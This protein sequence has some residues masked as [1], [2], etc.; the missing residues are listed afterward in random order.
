MRDEED[1][2]Q[3]APLPPQTPPAKKK[4][5]GITPAAAAWLVEGSWSLIA[6][7]SKS[8]MSQ[9]FPPLQRLSDEE[10]ELSAFEKLV[11]DEIWEMLAQV[12]N[13][14]LV[15]GAQGSS[16]KKDTSSSELQRWFGIW[17]QVENTWGNDSKE[18]RD[19]F[20]SVKSKC[21]G[22]KGLG[23]D[24]FTYLFECNPTICG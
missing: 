7:F 9:R 8:S 14:N 19:H 4:K 21:G 11:S 20:F 24:R 15:K 16:R 23:A 6:L 17:L 10:T 3:E 1:D 5:H 18:I 12:V 22:C 13:E 2:A